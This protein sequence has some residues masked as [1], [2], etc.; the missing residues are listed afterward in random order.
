MNQA[1]DK[2]RTKLPISK[3]SGKKYS[4]IE[5]L[6]IAIC[7]IHHLRKTLRLSEDYSYDE[8]STSPAPL[9]DS[10]FRSATAPKQWLAIQTGKPTTEGFPLVP[11]P[12][13]YPY[14]ERTM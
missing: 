13:P 12:N 8:R 3:P 5:C 11:E 4:K 14:D 2:L 7:Y 6:R 10:I 9:P 1:F